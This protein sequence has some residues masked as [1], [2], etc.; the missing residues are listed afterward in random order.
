M[1]YIEFSKSSS[2]QPYHYLDLWLFPKNSK[3]KVFQEV[4]DSYRSRKVM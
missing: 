1:N 2:V 3:Q 4:K